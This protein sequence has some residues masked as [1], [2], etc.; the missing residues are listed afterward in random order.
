MTID[1]PTAV[2]EIPRLDA[3]A[4]D[5]AAA[6]W[7]QAFHVAV[8][9]PVNS[10]LPA[11]Q[12]FSAAARLGWN[13]DG[14]LVLV[15]VTGNVRNEAENLD[16]LW[17]GDSVELYLA[18]APASPDRCQWVSAPGLSARFPK[19]RTFL[20]DHRQ[21]AELKS[22]PAEATV[23]SQSTATGYQIKALLPWRALG[24]VPELQR[25]VVCQIMVNNHARDSQ[26][27]DHLVWFPLLGAYGDSQKMHRLRL[28]QASHSPVS[29]RLLGQVNRRT[30]QTEFEV[31][32][33]PALAGQPVRV[34][35]TDGEL[36]AGTLQADTNGYARVQ[37]TGRNTEQAEAILEVGGKQADVL[38][39]LLPSLNTPARAWTI[40]TRVQVKPTVVLTLPIAPAPYRVAR[41]EPGQPWTTLA[42]NVPPGE[43]R[44]AGAQS[45]TLYEYAVRRSG[46]TPATDYFCAGSEVP[47]VDQRGTIV[48]LVEQSQAGPLTAEIRRLMFDL[49]GDGW[50]VVRHDV[51]TNQT[52]V[53]VKRLIQAQPAD[54]VFLLGQI[55]VPYSGDFRPDGHIDHAGAW[56]ADV[57]YGALEGEWTDS[58]VTQT[59]AK[60]VARQHNVPGDGKFDQSEIPGPVRLAVGRVDFHDLP[61]F[62]VAETTLLRRYLDRLHAY[63]QGEL[64]VVARGWV[65]DNFSSHK[66][67]FGYSGW[68]NL[69]TLLGPEN[70]VVRAWPNVE[71]ALHLWVAGCGPGG[72]ESMAGFGTTKQ[73]VATPLNAVFALLFGSY[74]ADWDMPNNLMRAA[75][76]SDGGA[77]TC[78]W[79]GRPHW[80]VHPMGMGATIGDC[81][82]LT[83]NNPASGYQPAGSFPRGVHIALLGDPTLRMHRVRPPTH[84]KVRATVRGMRLS[85]QASP[86]AGV[87]YH[88][89]RAAMELG[90]YE[91]LTESPIKTR[92]FTDPQGAADN[93][94]MVRAIALQLTPTG[95]YYNASQAAFAKFSKR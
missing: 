10:P 94:Y 88:V 50:Q 32:A 35:T 36:A 22:Q 24:I 39:L 64:P 61:A 31:I 7:D 95:S 4:I 17:K 91:R 63:R 45:G 44:D 30:G 8:L 54:A 83:Q 3:S 62:G 28:A 80:F 90:P 92:A 79:A 14:L 48:L 75:L 9:V 46:E 53:E 13:A 85:W 6:D 89:Y 67:R 20:H 66:E 57:F 56:P 11:R 18:P 47:L 1:A 71:P 93:Q 69:T 72:H 87:R 15:T 19:V 86:Q 73:L 58:S 51:A 74:F 76:A 25:E 38:P 49:V 82:R 52:P 78:G 43:F 12:T 2:Y 81:L 59:N 55:P 26:P 5:G 40:D 16:E 37:L 33:P 70:V 77:L 65:Q 34:C 42:T 21:S 60:T 29:A 27:Q 23:T 41:R 68:Q 84:L